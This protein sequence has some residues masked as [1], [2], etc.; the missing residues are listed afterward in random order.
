MFTLSCTTGL[1]LIY[2][3]A[4]EFLVKE[5]AKQLYK[6]VTLSPSSSSSRICT[7]ADEFSTTI[8][9]FARSSKAMLSSTT[10]LMKF[11]QAIVLGGTTVMVVLGWKS[12]SRKWEKEHSYIN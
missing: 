3:L 11:V 9:K 5:I 4:V 8:V 6:I 2:S 7:Q 10:R 1:L 12:E